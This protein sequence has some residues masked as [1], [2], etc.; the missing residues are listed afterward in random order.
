MPL[1]SLDPEWEDVVPLP[2]DDGVQPLAQI[3][4]TEE[5][6]EAM[7]Y[8]R[9]VMAKDE[10]SERVLKVTEDVIEM[11]PAHY[12]VWLYRAKT[13]FAL[14]KDLVEEKNFLNDMAL[15][16]QKNYQIWHHRQLIMDRIDD[17]T[18]E[19]EFTVTMFEKDCK[20]YH[21]WSYRQWLVRRFDLWDKGEIEYID[22]LLEQ[23]VRNNSAWNHRFFVVFG[24]EETVPK[25]I[26]DREIRVCEDAI[27]IAPQNLS[28]WSYVRGVLKKANLPLSTFEKTA[29]FYAPLDNPDKIRSSHAL[30]ILADIYAEKGEQK[31]RALIALDFL[32]KK[33]DPI[34]ANYWNYRAGL[35]KASS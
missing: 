24:R 31:E 19:T 1:Y 29:S 8:L 35:I 10:M 5:Y 28:P 25:D 2:Q 21:V 9:A 13:L 17:S 30:D 22:T 11:N 3:A 12:T 34:R 27:F 6:T 7:S 33:Y 18:G 16:H 15:R 32:A 26:V 20:N 4:Y 23:D 14:G